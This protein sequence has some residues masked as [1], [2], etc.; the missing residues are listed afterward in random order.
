MG[1]VEDDVVALTGNAHPCTA[2]LLAQH[3]LLLIHVV[4]DAPT[5]QGT[6]RAPD[7]C[8]ASGIA[9]A[10]VVPDDATE[11][12]TTDCAHSSA[13]CGFGNLL[14]A[15]VGIFGHTARQTEGCDEGRD[16]EKPSARRR[17]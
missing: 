14:L 8:S 7:Q 10:H 11:D 2:Q 9:V 6:Q 5:C 4:A 1:H 16:G 12:G 13:S 3:G 17:K 15:G